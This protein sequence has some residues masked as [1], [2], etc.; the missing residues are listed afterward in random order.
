MIFSLASTVFYY[1]SCGNDNDVVGWIAAILLFVLGFVYIGI[2]F[3]GGE[4]FGVSEPEKTEVKEQMVQW[5]KKFETLL[6]L[7]VGNIVF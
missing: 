6:R 2:H 3:C 5:S 4:K 1:F 7:Y